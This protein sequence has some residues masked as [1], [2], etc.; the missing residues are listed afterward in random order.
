MAQEPHVTA[1]LSPALIL[2]AGAC[3]AALAR[4]RLR[5]GLILASPVAAGIALAAL[6][7]GTTVDLSVFG[8]TLIWLRVDPLARIFAWAFL[9]A[10]FLA[11]IYGL[12]R[13]RI[14]EHWAALAYAGAALGGVLAGDL[15]TFLVFWELTTLFSTVLVWTGG[16]RDTYST[17][18][19]YLGFHVLSGLLLLA[20]TVALAH[21]G[22]PLSFGTFDLTQPVVWVILAAFGIKAAFPVVHLW[23]PDAYPE[24]SPF[25]TVVLSIFTT[26]LAIYA[27]L[28]GF[29]GA[30][31]LIPIG[32]VMVAF[33]SFYAFAVPDLRRAMCYAL[34]AQLGIMVM[35]IGIGTPLSLN[36]AIAA[37]V[38]SI[39]YQ[40]LVFMGLGAILHRT[41]TARGAELGGLLRQMPWTVLATIIGCLAMAG[42]PLFSGFTTK[43]MVF[44]AAHAQGPLWAWFVLLFG[45]AAAAIYAGLR[46]PLAML[47]RPPAFDGAATRVVDEA[48]QAMRIGMALTVVPCLLI[49]IWPAP[50][51][52]LLPVSLDWHPYTFDTL[53]FDTALGA[54]AILAFILGWR[55]RTLPERQCPRLWEADWFV[56]RAS[57]VMIALCVG[58]IGRGDRLVRIFCLA[59]VDNFIVTLRRHHGP[60][61]ILARTWPTGSTVLWVAVILTASLVLYAV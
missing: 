59:R 4:G 6:P 53:L 33:A 42:L 17:S 25:G 2:I 1:W 55:L 39:F 12:H 32:A 37:A 58:P 21:T 10:S 5:A 28:R 3:L 14:V 48:P 11:A 26:K 22:A 51:Y 30:E 50:L 23:L 56:R 40:A 45:A 16:G 61:G 13:R 7:I 31:P 52:G 43:T 57:P 19:R 36:G 27:L 9:G 35:G 46:V 49:G 47:L 8:T 24:A 60:R 54:G 44:E 29:P 34:I 15:I 41:G 18:L 38:A 20:G